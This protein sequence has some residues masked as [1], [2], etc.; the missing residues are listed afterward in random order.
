MN[1]DMKRCG[2]R[3]RQLRVKS[4]FTQETIAAALNVDR[5]FYSRIEAGKKGASVDLFIQLS[6]LLNVSL[7]HL[8]LGRYVIGQAENEDVA[9]LKFDI[10][11]LEAHLERFKENL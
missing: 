2:E 11:E 6:A 9:Q 5:S 4:G 1:Y 7:D 8:I 10:T 3:I